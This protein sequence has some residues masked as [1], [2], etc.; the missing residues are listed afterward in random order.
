MSETIKSLA[1]ASERTRLSPVAAKS[2]DTKGR[3]RAVTPC[4]VRTEYQRDRDRILHSKSFRRLKGKTQVFLDPKGDHYRTRLTHTLEVAQIART[5]SRALRL[6]ED[7]C[8]AVALGH[9]LGHTPFGHA[10]EDVLDRILPGGFRHQDQSLRVVDFLEKDGAGLNLTHETRAGIGAH[11]KGTGAIM[12]TAIGAQ[13]LEAGVVRVS[14]AIAYLNHDIE[15]AARSGILDLDDLPAGPMNVLGARR[16]ERIG[17]MVRDVIEATAQ[18]G[19]VSM[20]DAVLDA[21]QTLK[22]HMYEHVYPSPLIAVEVGK[23]KGVLNALVDRYTQAPNE[24]PGFY[25]RIAD[26]AGLTRAACDYVAGMTDRFALDRYRD[27]HLPKT[28]V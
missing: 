12:A 19:Q 25:Q 26:D 1:E 14:D 23:A 21:T 20:S 3:R 13:S 16:S 6:N 5:V 10:G 9:D 2:A 11:S 17:L 24:L 15:D 22:D 7:L 28:W 18:N 8:E 4:P 27:S